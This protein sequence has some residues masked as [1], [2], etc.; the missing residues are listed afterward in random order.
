MVEGQALASSPFNAAGVLVR[1]V[2]G[3]D[4]A[5]L[6]S[7]ANNIK[8]GTLDGFDNGRG[9][10]IGAPARRP[11]VAARRATTSRWWRRAAR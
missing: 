5:K 4:L 11:A 6:P 3:A 2:R 10:A 8:Q 9:V 7:I 1:G